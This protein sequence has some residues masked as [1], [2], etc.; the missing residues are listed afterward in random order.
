MGSSLNWIRENRKTASAQM[1]AHS[2]GQ[3]IAYAQQLLWSFQH[4]I[5]MG[6]H[7]AQGISSQLALMRRCGFWVLKW[8]PAEI[9]FW[10]VMLQFCW[11]ATHKGTCHWKGNFVPGIVE[12]LWHDPLA[13]TLLLDSADDTRKSTVHAWLLN[14]LLIGKMSRWRR[15]S[16][17]TLNQEEK[18]GFTWTR[19]T[20][21]SYML[22]C[23]VEWGERV[24]GIWFRAQ[25]ASFPRKTDT[26]N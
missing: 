6:A 26:L 21:L 12:Q 1:L 17:D 10:Q 4:S 9:R 25:F 11:V 2:D 7:W 18:M 14:V 3:T 15:H 8:V 22:R 23:L 16:S 24:S 20:Y 13:N 5:I 19:R